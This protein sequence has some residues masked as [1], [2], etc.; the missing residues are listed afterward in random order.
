MT[1]NHSGAA[2]YVVE[3]KAGRGV[4]ELADVPTHGFHRVLGHSF[5][6]GLDPLECVSFPPQQLTVLL[7]RHVLPLAVQAVPVI[8]QPFNHYLRFQEHLSNKEQQNVSTFM[9]C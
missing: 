4:S 1:R 2:T 5:H 8:N 6:D 9:I 3:Q 7:E